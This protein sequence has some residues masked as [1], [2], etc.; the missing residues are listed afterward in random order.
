M[1]KKIFLVLTLILVLGIIVYCVFSYGKSQERDN[2]KQSNVED[3]VEEVDN[4]LKGAE[5]ENIDIPKYLVDNGIFFDYYVASYK[6]LST[7]TIEEKVGQLIL[8][9]CPQKDAIASITNY[10]LG[11]FVLFEEDFKNKTSDA[12]VSIINGYQNVSSI[13]MIIAVD[14]EGGTV[15][16][17]SNN[18]NLANKKF[19]S[20]QSIY[21]SGGLKAIQEDTLKKAEILKNLKIN[22]NLAPVAD[23]SLE[24]SDYIYKRTLG[25]SAEETG[26]Y[27]SEVVKTMQSSGLSSTLK[28]F[29]GYGDNVDTHKGMSIDKRPYNTFKKSDF[30]PFIDGI[31]AGVES[32]LVCHN[33]VEAMDTSFPA[34]LSPSVHQ[35][36]RKDLNFTGVVM[37][38]DLSM[39]AIKEYTKNI[40]PAIKAVLAG[41][42]MLIMTNFEEGYNSILEAVSTG[43]IS[44]EQINKAVFKVLAWKYYMKILK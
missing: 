33:I 30:I 10:K 8:A 15:V 32:I 5:K 40:N 23:V 9:R 3:V 31:N 35:V 29:P 38:D 27:V 44:Q 2:N 34:S 14:E 12:V 26:K 24:P 25:K 16:R 1:F 42:D 22:V 4:P 39:D 37:T 18:P 11:G 28:H 17:I 6:K 21:K 20:A 13:P 7:L 36:L 41:N 43:V 19:Q